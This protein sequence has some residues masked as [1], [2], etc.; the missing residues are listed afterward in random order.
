MRSFFMKLF[1]RKIFFCQSDGSSGK[2]EDTDQVRD[3]HKSVEGIGDVPKQSKVHGSTND[4]NEGI[5][6]EERADE[7]FAAEEFDAAGAV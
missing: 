5:Y 7:L 1:F 4:R 2:K 3:C 6:H